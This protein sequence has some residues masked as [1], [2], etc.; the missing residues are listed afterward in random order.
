MSLEQ[1]LLWEQWAEYTLQG[2]GR[3]H[4]VSDGFGSNSQ[5][6]RGLYLLDDF[7]QLQRLVIAK[8]VHVLYY[9]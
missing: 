5:V 2:Q 3:G 7:Q 4:R 1:L 6:N 8:T 9:Y